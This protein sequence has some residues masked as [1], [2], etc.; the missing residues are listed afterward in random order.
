MYEGMTPPGIS[1][2]PPTS[3]T[4]IYSSFIISLSEEWMDEKDFLIL[5]Y[6]MT[7]I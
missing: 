7:S 4:Y 1:L 6:L 3:P 2:I 5:W